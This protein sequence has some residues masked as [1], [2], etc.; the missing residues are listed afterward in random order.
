MFNMEVNMKKRKSHNEFIRQLKTINSNIEILSNYEGYRAKVKVRCLCCGN[1][2]ETDAGSLLQG[3]GCPN[4]AVVK[5]SEKQSRSFTQFV[6]ELEDVN[7]NVI[8][9]SNYK[10]CK[11]KVRCKCKICGNVWDVTPDGLLRGCGC[12]N[13]KAVKIGE[14]KKYTNDIFIEKLSLINQ[15]ITPLTE[16]IDSCTKISCKCNICGSIWKAKP[17]HLLCG[18]GCPHCKLSIGEKKIAKW[19]TMNNIHYESQKKFNGLVGIGKR[20]LRYDFYIPDFNVLIEFNGKQHECPMNFS[21]KSDGTEVINFERTKEN[22][23]IKE[24]FAKEHKIQLIEIW[25]YDIKNIDT[26]LNNLFGKRMEE[27]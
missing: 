13:C 21:G 15:N 18:H 20:N 6:S 14:L 16:Y 2:W 10:N 19:L 3:H 4:C 23:S 7:P 1:V 17:N 22:Y 5:S 24:K 9:L 12:P 25:Y 27:V 8:V 26:I 11:T